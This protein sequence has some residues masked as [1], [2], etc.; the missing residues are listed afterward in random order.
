[1]ENWI[2][3]YPG[4]FTTDG[5]IIY[6]KICDKRIPSSKKH[7]VDQHVKTASHVAE[8]NKFFPSNRQQLLTQ[9]TFTSTSFSQ[10]TEFCKDLCELLVGCNIPFHQLN[11]EIFRKFMKKFCTNQIIP[12]ESTIRKNYLTALYQDVLAEV[13]A[14][15]SNNLV[16]AVISADETTD[17]CQRYSQ[18]DYWKINNRTFFS[19]LGCL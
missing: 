3:N 1:M 2:K 14:D 13:R 7:L 15:I 19:P 9:M 5:T 10:K 11:N 12:K 17:S 16:W 8:K 6:C 4:Q 18:F